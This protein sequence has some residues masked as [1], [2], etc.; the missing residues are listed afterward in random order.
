[1][2]RKD[3]PNLITS[4]RII[5][6][7]PMAVLLLQGQYRLALL[8]MLLAGLSDALDGF[9]AKHYGWTSRLG[10]ILDPIADKLLLVVAYLSLGWIGMLPWWLISVVLL[11]DA[12]IVSGALAYHALFGRYDMEPSILSKINT[13]MQILLVL[14]VMYSLAVMALPVGLMGLLSYG[15]LLTTLLSGADYVLRWGYR[16]YRAHKENRP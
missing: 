2:K 10:S 6:V 7:I 16:A 14:V 15:V 4:I 5:A 9:L 12:V 3:I 8:V 1:M 13:F 11:R